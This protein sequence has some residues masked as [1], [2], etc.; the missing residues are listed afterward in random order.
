M[1]KILDFQGQ[2][3]EKEVIFI[4]FCIKKKLYKPVTIDKIMEGTKF[5]FTKGHL[6]PEI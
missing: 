4:L 2:I 6:S 3:F 1:T 5:G